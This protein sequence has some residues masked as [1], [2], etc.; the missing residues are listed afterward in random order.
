MQWAI[1]LLIKTNRKFA[2]IIM[3]NESE[4]SEEIVK[5]KLL[6]DKIVKNELIH[7]GVFEN[8]GN[9]HCYVIKKTKK[10]KE[11][12][13]SEQEWTEIKIHLASVYGINDSS[14][15]TEI[16]NNF[17]KFIQ[18]I[19]GKHLGKFLGGP[20]AQK[21]ISFEYEIL[22]RNIL[23]ESYISNL[24]EHVIEPFFEMRNNLGNLLSISD[25][26]D[27]KEKI[28]Q[29]LRINYLLDL[30]ERN[31]LVREKIIN[32][33]YIH[34]NIEYLKKLIVANEKEE[35][36]NDILSTINNQLIRDRVIRDRIIL[37]FIFI[38]SLWVFIKLFNAF[39]HIK[40]KFFSGN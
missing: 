2:V 19:N 3:I 9:A 37:I 14:G 13:L 17:T 31:L 32:G 33:F 18:T 1:T 16:Y 22:L 20:I 34:Y 40:G 21:E 10:S 39:K 8:I 36:R 35:K 23:I 11:S 7:L 12:S 38:F 29:K 30:T 27:K 25:K 24:D 15:M 28:I 6:A 5:V 4:L 26:F